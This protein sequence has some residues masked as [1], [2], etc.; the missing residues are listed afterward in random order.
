ML[1]AKEEEAER[2]RAEA[3]KEAEALRVKLVEAEDTGNALDSLSVLAQKRE[4]KVAVAALLEMEGAEHIAL[5]QFV[6]S[7][8]APNREALLSGI[9]RLGRM[10]Q[11]DLRRQRRRD[12][13]RFGRHQKV[14]RGL[15][16]V[17][18]LQSIECFVDIDSVG[19]RHHHLQLYILQQ[20]EW[21]P[22]FT[23]IHSGH[24]MQSRSHHQ[25]RPLFLQKL[26]FLHKHVAVQRV[27][28]R[29][30]LETTQHIERRVVVPPHHDIR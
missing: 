1:R 6:D 8:C 24:R 4:H 16:I 15:F 2:K 13:A 23:A 29:R 18:E 22:A 30:M 12:L 17:A 14:E 21:D 10:H 7:E 9:A 28:L 20:T 25:R 3:V 26:I 5:V 19:R 11:F 27:A